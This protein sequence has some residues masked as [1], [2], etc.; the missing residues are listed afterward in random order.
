MGTKFES[1]RTCD[2]RMNDQFPF[3]PTSFYYPSLLFEVALIDSNG[4]KRVVDETPLSERTL[5]GFL[6]SRNSKGDEGCPRLRQGTAR[7][8]LSVD[9]RR[10]ATRNWSV[11]HLGQSRQSRSGRRR[12]RKSSTLRRRGRNSS[13][14]I[15]LSHLAKSARRGQSK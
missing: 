6:R 13:C 1:K 3:M 14:P 11:D 8:T 5:R 10:G 7:A 9:H 2:L 4:R 12:S 15:R